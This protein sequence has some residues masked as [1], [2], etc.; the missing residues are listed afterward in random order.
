MVQ[1]ML[2]DK[3]PITRVTATIDDLKSIAKVNITSEKDPKSS[4][5]KILYTKLGE[6]RRDSRNETIGIMGSVSFHSKP[7]PMWSGFMQHVE[8]HLPHPGKG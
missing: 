1:Y 7:M 4:H 5:G 2:W 3:W 6:F 8:S